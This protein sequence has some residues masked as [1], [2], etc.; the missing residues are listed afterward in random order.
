[1]AR[2]DQ[3]TKLTST[4]LFMLV[5]LVLSISASALISSANYHSESVFYALPEKSIDTLTTNHVSITEVS[6]IASEILPSSEVEVGTTHPHYPIF[7]P[8]KMSGQKNRR[9]STTCCQRFAKRTTRYA[10]TVVC[11]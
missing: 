3:T 1:M 5:V 7:L 2:L 10:R 8:S 9:F 11:C 4:D 6:N